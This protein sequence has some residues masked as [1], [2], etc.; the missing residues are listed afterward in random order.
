[1]NNKIKFYRLKQ[2][3]SLIQLSKFTGLSSGYLC[4]LEK[5]SRNNPSFLSMSKISNALNKSIADIFF[6]E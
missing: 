2:G 1:M 5:G 4:H 3:I 6:N